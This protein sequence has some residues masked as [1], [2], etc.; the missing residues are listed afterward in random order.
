MQTLRK[1]DQRGTANFGWLNSAHSFSFGS[2]FD[3]EH[4]GFGP[5]RVINEDRVQPAKGFDTHGHRDMEILTYVLD[6]ALAHKDSMGN[7]S[8]I[9]RGDVQRM[10]AG[11][12]VTHSECNDSDS[13]SVHFLQIWIEPAQVGIDPSYE[14]QRIDVRDTPNRWRVLAS[15][16][17]KA[18]AVRVHQDIDLLG[19]WIEANQTLAYELDGGRQYWLQVARGSVEANGQTL[20]EGD[21]L[22][23][24]DQ[25]ALSVMARGDAEVLLFD[26]PAS[27]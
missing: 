24:R 4:M 22:A 25:K 13:D 23:I 17:G 2:Y 16:R 26:L 20:T 21:G 9:E 12:G 8:V 6:G 19:A 10:S 27:M 11:T 3:P 14:Q 7:G 5:L 15:G 18:G 1:A